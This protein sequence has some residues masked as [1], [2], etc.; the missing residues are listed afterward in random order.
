MHTSFR[1]SHLRGM[2]QSRRRASKADGITSTSE[3]HPVNLD[4]LPKLITFSRQLPLKLHAPR[5]SS[6]N[7][8]DRPKSA[9]VRSCVLLCPKSLAVAGSCEEAELEVKRCRDAYDQ[10][11][12]KFMVARDK[13]NDFEEKC[14]PQNTVSPEPYMECLCCGHQSSH[15]N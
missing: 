10:F 9:S 15:V 8:I 13:A 5:R 4:G 2:A 1:Q 11:S 7:L 12:E 14:C 3:E 6:I